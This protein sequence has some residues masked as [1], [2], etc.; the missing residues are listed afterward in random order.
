MYAGVTSRGHLGIVAKEYTILKF[1]VIHSYS[2]ISPDPL[3]SQHHVYPFSS[4][5]SQQLH[6]IDSA[7]KPGLTLN[8]IFMDP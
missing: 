4:K 2:T 1:I 7:D 8:L 5:F 3:H 6:A